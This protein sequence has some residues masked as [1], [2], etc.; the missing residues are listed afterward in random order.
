M[1]FPRKALREVVE[2]QV[3]LQVLVL[4]QG[5]DT[6]AV[7]VIK[8]EVDWK[9]SKL[10]VLVEHLRSICDR[11]SAEIERA[12]ISRGEWSFLPKYKDLVKSEA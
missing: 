6:C 12:V 7:N 5:W 11:E 3:E 9:E 8:M 1:N 2:L 10:P 4:A